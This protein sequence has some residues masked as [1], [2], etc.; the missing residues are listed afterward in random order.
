MP[1][2]VLAAA[3]AVLL[4]SVSSDGGLASPHPASAPAADAHIGVPVEASECTG[5]DC[6]GDKNCGVHAPA[7]AAQSSSNC[8]DS[9]RGVGSSDENPCR[10]PSRLIDLDSDG[11]LPKNR[12]SESWLSPLSTTAL[13]PVRGSCSEREA[14]NDGRLTSR[15]D[16]GPRES[17][18]L[19]HDGVTQCSASMHVRVGDSERRDAGD[20]AVSELCDDDV[21][22]A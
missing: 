18:V 11:V 5:S 22:G 14:A 6:C 17:G 9:D 13:L 15:L 21:A 16:R 2:G 3:G 19:T 7:S 4:A 20:A 10:A 12:L 1:P 8:R